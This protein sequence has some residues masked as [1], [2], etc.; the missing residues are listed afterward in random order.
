MTCHKNDLAGSSGMR[1]QH[2]VTHEQGTSE[3][4]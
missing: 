3:S 1:Q 4:V 2:D